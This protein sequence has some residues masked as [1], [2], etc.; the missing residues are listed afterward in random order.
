MSII[1]E[2]VELNTYC[3]KAVYYEMADS[4]EY[5]RKDVP[6]VYRRV[7]QQLTLILDMD[8]R[9]PMGFKLKGFKHFFLRYLKPKYDLQD[10]HFMRLIDVL[11]KALSVGG[12]AI[13][14]AVDRQ[15]AYRQ[16]LEIAE[17]DGVLV[18]EFPKS[19]SS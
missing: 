17:Q 11:Q 14:D 12:D 7:D 13:F 4:L 10:Q 9:E 15:A 3:A 6:T 16:A 19:V 5:V 18:D 2:K 8:T 1:G